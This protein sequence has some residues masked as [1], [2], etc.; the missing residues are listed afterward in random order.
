VDGDNR[1]N[2]VMSSD[3]I[4]KIS[5]NVYNDVL[6]LYLSIA[7]KSRHR[8]TTLRLIERNKAFVLKL[9]ITHKYKAED[10]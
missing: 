6:I 8:S 3:S 9:L 2:S 7:C 1:I 10:I 4:R 5:I